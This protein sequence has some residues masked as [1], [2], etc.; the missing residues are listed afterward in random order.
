MPTRTALGLPDVRG[1]VPL[2]ACLAID[3]FGGGCVAPLL[4]LFLNHVDRIPLGRAGLI[5]TLASLASIAVPAVVAQL[6]DRFGSRNLVLFAQVAQCAAYVVFLTGRSEV[7]VFGCALVAVAGQR[8]FWSSIFSLLSDVAGDG[9]RDRW[10]A[11]GG[12]MQS[13][14]F[15]LGSLAAGVLLAIGGNGPLIAAMAVNATTFLVA[16]G[17]LTRLRVHHEPVRL[18][19]ARQVRLRD[20]P[21]FV[22]LIAVNG[23][24]ALC[25]M[26]L[27][28]GLSV[29]VVE[30][31]PAPGWIVGVLLAL[32]SVALATTQTVVVRRSAGRRRTRVLSLAGVLLAAWGLL[33]A[34]L[35]HLPAVLVVPVLLLATLAFAAGSVMHSATSN[36]LAAAI[37]PAEGRGKYL[38]YWQYSFTLAQVV[39]PAFFAQLFDVRADL[40]WLVAAVL[41]LGAAVAVVVLE[42]RLPRS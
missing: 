16:A 10:F 18:N 41:A 2:L 30:A 31:L 38:S 35:L 32:V 7:L 25:L 27:G 3:S 19:G 40:P 29:Y 34:A 37:S 8:M 21:P 26:L 39:V 22:A 36:A 15:G 28:V 4:L 13:T 6:I 12:M 11:L 24:L 1:R 17:L 5:I 14:G 42:P 20:D 9:D 23:V 33:M